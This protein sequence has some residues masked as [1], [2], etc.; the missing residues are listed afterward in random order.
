VAVLR[1]TVNL[2][3]DTDQMLRAKFIMNVAF[4]G[5]LEKVPR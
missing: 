5:S 3:T 1:F 4:S 2:F